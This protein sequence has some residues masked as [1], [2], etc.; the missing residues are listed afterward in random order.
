[1]ST[2]PPGQEITKPDQPTPYYAIDHADDIFEMSPDIEVDI[3]S[4]EP[5]V[6]L[7]MRL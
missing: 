6:K 3:A 5:I 4:D 2:N 1:M 7:T